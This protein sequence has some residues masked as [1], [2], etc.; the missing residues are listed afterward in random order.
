MVFHWRRS[1]RNSSQISN[2][3]FH[4][5]ADLNNAVV[6][7]VSSRPL[8]FMYSSSCSNL[9]VTVHRTRFTFGITVTI[10]FHNVFN[11]LLRSR[12]LSLFFTQSYLVLNTFLTQSLLVLDSLCAIYCIRFLYDWSFYL[13][14][15]ITYVCYFVASCLFLLRHSSHGNAL[16]CYQK[17]SSFFLKVPLS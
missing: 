9:L 14:Q 5:L 6:W 1:D 12:Y 8:H 15:H 4:I 16:C 13:C 3:L 10:M 17:R 11:S 7:M 2:T